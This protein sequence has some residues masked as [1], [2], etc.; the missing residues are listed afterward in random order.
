MEKYRK[1]STLSQQPFRNLFVTPRVP[2]V[3]VVPV[4]LDGKFLHYVLDL[5]N[6]DPRNVTLSVTS[7]STFKYLGLMLYKIVDCI[8]GVFILQRVSLR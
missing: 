8:Y 7:R 5:E 6:L 2:E 3:R 1:L 4:F